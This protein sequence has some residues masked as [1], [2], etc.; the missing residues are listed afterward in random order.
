MIILKNKFI[1]IFLA[2]VL[3]FSNFVTPVFA[4]DGV[5]GNVSERS[6][7]QQLSNKYTDAIY[8]DSWQ[9][10][11]TITLLDEQT[12]KKSVFV[13]PAINNG[14]IDKNVFESNLPK[15]LKLVDFQVVDNTNFVNNNNIRL[16]AVETLY[17]IGCLTLSLAEFAVNP[18][19]WNG[20]NVVLDGAA[21]VL[22]FVPSVT[23]VTRMIKNSDKLADAMKWGVARYDDLRDAKSGISRFKN[24]EAHHIIEKRFADVFE[25]NEKSMFAITIHKNDHNLITR[26]MQ[27]KIPYRTGSD[28]SDLSE[29][30]IKRKMIEGYDELYSETGDDL[31]KFLSKF[32][33]E[34]D[35][36]STS[37]RVKVKVP[38]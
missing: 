32:V 12:N 30:Y 17:D 16:F 34:S 21:V 8:G 31:Y 15:N 27:K 26:K 11:Y 20:F 13:I 37:K 24:Y 5:K 7:Q 29:G 25:V 6:I 1:S 14:K 28:Y 18:T 19:F 23:G 38:N 33:K 36:I 35:Q 10:K 22:P 3:L 4:A 9:R 2:V